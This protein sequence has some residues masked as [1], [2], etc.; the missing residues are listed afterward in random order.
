MTFIKASEREE[1]R[2]DP[3]LR[4]GPLPGAVLRIQLE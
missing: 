4:P 2:P 1:L 3:G